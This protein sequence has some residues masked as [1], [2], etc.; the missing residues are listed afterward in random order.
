MYTYLGTI[1]VMDGLI[2][3]SLLIDA[4]NAMQFP[5]ILFLA[6]HYNAMQCNMQVLSAL[7]PLDEVP[8]SYE[9]IGRCH[10]ISSLHLAV[11]AYTHAHTRTGQLD[12]IYVELFCIVGCD[13]AQLR[14]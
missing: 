11:C 7:L 5:A 8:S 6:I 9:Q 4:I 12:G 10:S 2:D 13:G 1:I 14:V 3:E